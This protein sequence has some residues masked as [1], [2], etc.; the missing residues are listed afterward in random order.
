MSVIEG[1]GVYIVVLDQIIAIGRESSPKIKPQWK[2]LREVGW[3]GF[4]WKTCMG[5]YEI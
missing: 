4:G 5:D 3:E 2:G 1:I